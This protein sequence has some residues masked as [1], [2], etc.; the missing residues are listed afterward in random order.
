MDKRFV[1]VDQR[2][3]QMVF[4]RISRP[5]KKKVLELVKQEGYDS[6]SDYI[7]S[8][9]TKDLKDRGVID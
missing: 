8:L 6:Q 3:V 7:L 2:K 1:P 9:I 5:M 4:A